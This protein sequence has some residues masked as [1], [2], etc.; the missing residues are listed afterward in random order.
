MQQKTVTIAGVACEMI[1]HDGIT[2][3]SLPSLRARTTLKALTPQEALLATRSVRA[4]NDL[5]NMLVKE[6]HHTKTKAKPD[7]G[8]LTNKKH[9]EKQHAIAHIDGYFIDRDEAQNQIL[10]CRITHGMVVLEALEEYSNHS[11][12]ANATNRTTKTEFDIELSEIAPF[13]IVDW[14]GFFV[15]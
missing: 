4:K 6:G 7:S 5:G 8:L 1:S 11:Y 10:E 14:R 15:V 12:V 3:T 13:T 9:A 2:W